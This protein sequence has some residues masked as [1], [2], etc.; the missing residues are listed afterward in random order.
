[1][2]DR[3]AHAECAEMIP[4]T[5]RDIDH[6]KVYVCVHVFE[7]SR[8]VLY[9]TRPDG[10]W[11]MLCGATHADSSDEYRVVGLGHLIAMDPSLTEVLDLLPQEEAERSEV[12]ANWE[13]NAF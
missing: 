1:M 8:P 13:R 10:D 7:R 3:K 9:V 5:P 12:G 6:T 4:V 11:C 2:S